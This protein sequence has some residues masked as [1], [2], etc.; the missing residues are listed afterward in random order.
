[1]NRLTTAI[2][3]LILMIST[4]CSTNNDKDTAKGSTANVKPTNQPPRPQNAILA[5]NFLWQEPTVKL[6][7]WMI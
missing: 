5:P 6:S 7:G 2:T 3:I 1:M 4:G